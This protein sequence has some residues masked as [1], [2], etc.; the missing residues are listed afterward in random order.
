MAKLL[1]GDYETPVG[2]PNSC[3]IRE[4]GQRKMIE[5][6]IHKTRGRITKVC[7][8]PSNEEKLDAIR[9]DILEKMAK[10]L[11]KWGVDQNQILAITGKDEIGKGLNWTDIGVLM[12]HILLRWVTIY[13]RIPDDKHILKELMEGDVDPA[14]IH[15]AYTEVAQFFGFRDYDELTSY[16]ELGEQSEKDGL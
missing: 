7:K 1:K 16:I 6:G 4:L 2:S 5:S 11:S 3:D 13:S 15:H 14:D 8:R 9:N 12:D 10:I